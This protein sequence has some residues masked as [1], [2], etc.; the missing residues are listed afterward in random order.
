MSENRL[1]RAVN[2]IPLIMAG[3]GSKVKIKSISGGRGLKQRLCDLGLYEG[4][5][6]EL[7]KSS[8]SGPVILKVLDSRIVIGRGQAHKIM[9][10]IL[11]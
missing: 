6:V 8:I 10:E 9:V 4:A 11:K 2:S 5:I 1:N 3:N 7:V